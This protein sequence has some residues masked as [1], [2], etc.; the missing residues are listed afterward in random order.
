MVVVVDEVR[1]VGLVVP[2]PD[3]VRRGPGHLSPVVVL[4]LPLKMSPSKILLPKSKFSCFHWAHIVVLL[5]SDLPCGSA[6]A[7][8]PCHRV[9]KT[10]WT[11]RKKHI[12]ES[13]VFGERWKRWRRDLRWATKW[14]LDCLDSKPAVSEGPKTTCSPKPDLSGKGAFSRSYVIRVQ[15]CVH[16]F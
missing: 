2:S 7:G 3:G 8:I 4:V 5:G 15:L 13:L 6:V 12:F 14:I 10:P 16:F 11:H 9:A 1:L